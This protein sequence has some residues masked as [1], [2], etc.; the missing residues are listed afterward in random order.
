MT[1]IET[2]TVTYQ[3]VTLREAPLRAT[4]A[5]AEADELRGAEVEAFLKML[6][7]LTAEQW[8]AAGYETWIAA[9]DELRVVAWNEAGNEAGN[10]LQGAARSAAAGAARRACSEARV[11]ARVAAW[12]LVARD[13]IAVEHFNIL[14][15]PMRAAGID[16][17]NLVASNHKEG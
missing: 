9:G 14:T 13:L 15:A 7:E 12:G 3:S 17:D 6:P 16:F 8:D 2:K 10:E 11:E 4:R 5:E 1:I